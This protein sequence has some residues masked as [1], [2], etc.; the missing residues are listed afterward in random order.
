[1]N[2]QQHIER[3]TPDES[4]S[5]VD[6]KRLR[7]AVAEA[8]ELLASGAPQQALARIGPLS[9]LAER[10][11]VGAYVFGLIYFNADDPRTALGWLEQAVVLNPAHADALAARAVVQQR[12]GQPRD[13]LASYE[14][15]LALRPNDVDTL[16]YIGITLQSLGQMAQALDAYEDVLRADPD[17]VE[18]LTNRGVLLQRFQRFEDALGCFTAIERVQPDN[19]RNL[20]NK[21][22]VLQRLDRHEEA[23]A[24]CQAAARRSP[25]D[26]DTEFNC[27]NVLVSL[28][29]FD[30]AIECYDRA[31]VFGHAQSQTLLAKGIAL[32]GLGRA[33]AALEAYDA[34][35]DLDPGLCEAL[36][37]RGNALHELGRLAEAIESYDDALTIRPSFVP[38]LV[39][40]AT[41]FLRC[42]RYQDAV[43]SC[44]DA[45]R[46]DPRSAR[47]T[48]LRGAALHKLGRLDD[49]LDAL[50]H[51]AKSD[52][53]IAET[54]LNR[55]N[56]LM[57][58]ERPEAAIASY[59]EALRVRPGYPEALSGLGVAL[60]ELGRVDE[61][62]ARFD[63]A[64]QYRPS[65]AD[66]RNNR[67]GVLLLSGI[68][69]AGFDDLESRW[70][71]SDAP[72]KT[73]VSALPIW[74]GGDLRGKSILVWDEQGHGDLIQFSRYLPCLVELGAEVTFLCRTSMHRLLR[75]MNCPVRLVDSID[76]SATFSAQS[77]LMS[78]PRGFQT[79][80]DTI[81]AGVP[82]LHPE[83][84]LVASWA[85]RIGGEGFRI[86]ICW[87]GNSVLNL[88]RSIPLE[89][90]APL[91]AIEGVRLLSLRKE[92]ESLE[93]DAKGHRFTIEKLGD[94][95]D[96]GPDAFVDC[97][98]VM[99]T[100]DL[101]VTSDT[102][103][104][105]LAGALGRPVLLA[106]KH[107][108]DWRWLRARDDSP[109]YPTMRLFRQARRGDWDDVLL[110]IARWVEPLVAARNVTQQSL[111]QVNRI[112]VPMS[113]GE[114]VDKITILEIK[115]CRI[116]DPAKLTN[117]RH[118][119][120]LLRMAR[121][122]A[123][124][125]G[126]ELRELERSL[127]D[128]NTRLWQLQDRLRARRASPRGGDELFELAQEFCTASDT[129]ARLK[130]A[131]DALVGSAIVEE[132]S[133]PIGDPASGL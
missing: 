123:G 130:R 126:T 95:F 66:A 15:L 118:E 39:N 65:Y 30:E 70:D 21:A 16:F 112:N 35:L 10:S 74:D 12:L 31:L 22:S 80:L 42:G 7:D 84:D 5:T 13:A 127:A 67:A 103:I 14:A 87:Q 85:E 28:G 94:D 40:R 117:V 8:F 104:A 99:A 52:P 73:V 49:A 61:A 37:N 106:L 44:D 86:G 54:W 26:S 77:A 51:A 121:L 6:R 90:F 9:E 23:L 3:G 120:A 64:L 71:R 110:H 63:E 32:H 105:H 91:A 131:V 109:W 19:T 114:L 58:L 50:D 2:A 46:H 4:S 24:A 25:L 18:A 88:Q 101:V 108:A 83:P 125:G 41:V 53:T 27:G 79:M 20:A 113:V 69:K 72:P 56:V 100:L 124:L 82:Y 89:S 129:R 36:C 116:A 98:A 17:H 33:E 76:P 133:W 97:A 59:E 96:S 75:S 47:A 81:P 68:L 115:E 132:K 78:L 55:G 43:A 62:L 48:G 34:A 1:M 122:Q 128:V 38:A 60:K 92:Q 119:L 93:V 45:L 107:A 11:D 102:S 111:R 57:E 29:R